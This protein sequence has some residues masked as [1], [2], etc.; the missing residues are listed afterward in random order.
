M[1]FIESYTIS[2]TKLKEE[3]IT[4]D[5]LLSDHL[6]WEHRLALPYPDLVHLGWILESRR[7]PQLRVGFLTIL[8]EDEGNEGPIGTTLIQCLWAQYPLQHH[9]RTV[10]KTPYL[11]YLNFHVY[12]DIYLQSTLWTTILKL[13]LLGT[14]RLPERRSFYPGRIRSVGRVFC[15][16]VSLFLLGDIADLMKSSQ[17]S[18][19][20]SSVPHIYQAIGYNLQPPELWEESSCLVGGEHKAGYFQILSYPQL[21]EKTITKTV[22]HKI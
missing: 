17:I 9:L 19:L 12:Q 21:S 11:K 22:M 4:W 16:S 7:S 15:S 18:P 10:W 5:H 8:Y 1:F 2:Y 3:S 13:W 14:I 20:Y 6:Q